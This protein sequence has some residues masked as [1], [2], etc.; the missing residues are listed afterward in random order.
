MFGPAVSAHRDPEFPA[1]GG[2]VEGHAP[3]AL[4][5]VL[6][7]LQQQVTS[8]VVPRARERAVSR[9]VLVFMRGVARARG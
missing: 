9:E 1:D 5:H 8:R 3:R 4:L 6:H 7:V 2:E